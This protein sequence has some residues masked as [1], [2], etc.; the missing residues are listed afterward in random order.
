MHPNE[1]LAFATAGEPDTVAGGRAILSRK[2]RSHSLAD[3]PPH[4]GAGI[5]IK[6]DAWVSGWHPAATELMVLKKAYSSQKKLAMF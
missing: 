2:S 3:I 5:A 1:P 6:G 4:P